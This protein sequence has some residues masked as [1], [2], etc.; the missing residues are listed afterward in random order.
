MVVNTTPPEARDSAFCK[1]LAAVGLN[2]RLADQVAAHRERAE[3][4]VVQVV[5]V[6]DDDDGR[7]FH[8]RFAH[9]LPGIEGHQQALARPLRVPDHPHLAVAPGTAGLHRAGHG[10]LHGVELV[11]ARDDLGD[12]ARACRQRP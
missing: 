12:A 4:L 10:P 3:Q 11:I 1:I 5:A 8:R 2:R 9:Q 6:G 7:V